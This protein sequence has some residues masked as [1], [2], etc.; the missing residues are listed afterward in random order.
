MA[1]FALPFAAAGVFL[2]TKAFDSWI[3]QA[4][5][6]QAWVSSL[7]ALVFGGV[8]FGIWA[9]LPWVRRTQLAEY[10]SKRMHPES[11]WLWRPEWATGRISSQGGRAAIG[12]WVF[13][14][15]WNAV[16]APLLWVLPEEVASGNKEALIGALF[17]AVG[18]A[19]LVWAVRTTWRW[20]RFG[21][22][23]F[24]LAS[25]PGVIG[26]RLAGRV[27][28]GT[29]VRPEAGFEARLV[30]VAVRISGSGKNRSRH[31]DVRWEETRQIGFTQFHA[32]R[33]GTEVPIEFT[34]PYRLDSS[35]EKEGQSWVE[36]RLE[37][38]A[39]LS[40]IDYLACFEV[41]VYRTPE[42]SP[43]VTDA[44][45]ASDVRPMPA[46]SFSTSEAG[47]FSDESRIRIQR[48]KQG[49]TEFYFPPA[50]NLF[51]ALGLTAFAAIW[52]AIVWFLATSDGGARIMAVFFGFFEVIILW[53]VCRYW[54]RLTRVIAGPSGLEI[55][56]RT[57]LAARKRLVPAGL[58]HTIVADVNGQANSKPFYDIRILG[59]RG[60]KRGVAGDMM[61]DKREAEWLASEMWR[62]LGRSAAPPARGGDSHSEHGR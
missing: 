52:T 61:R 18:L 30:C 25:L 45:A 46:R 37:L 33:L 26:G 19:L 12:V 21:R 35:S 17:P 3:H 51:A 41:P 53:G 34:I 16:S 39:E 54:F 7:M 10:E 48:T 40:G 28:L 5:T 14:L 58:I 29:D 4:G 11:P 59:E 62:A 42:S 15:F 60:E 38:A 47:S 44:D 27:S 43:D 22:S 20:K 55:R 56:T 49:A 9:A 2:A 32:G 8:G 1:L 57:L 23:V 24:E 6:Q 31:E 36:W 13:A 50:R